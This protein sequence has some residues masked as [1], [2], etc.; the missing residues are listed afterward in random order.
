[1]WVGII[2]DNS[3]DFSVDD[4]NPLQQVALNSV[5]PRMWSDVDVDKLEKPDTFKRVLT[6]SSTD[7]WKVRLRTPITSSA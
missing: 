5:V 2:C 7:M 4:P 3:V 1:M 6:N